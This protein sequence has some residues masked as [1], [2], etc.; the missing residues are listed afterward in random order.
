MVCLLR[1]RS[2]FEKLYKGVEG[3]RHHRIDK[4]ETHKVQKKR[5]SHFFFVCFKNSSC[6]VCICIGPPWE[7]AN[8]DIKRFK[9]EEDWY[10]SKKYSRHEVLSI[11]NVTC[12]IKINKN[13]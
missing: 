5:A 10:F 4:F 6:R 3:V 12:Q 13:T 9:T 7:N 2:D 11:W 1:V 8:L